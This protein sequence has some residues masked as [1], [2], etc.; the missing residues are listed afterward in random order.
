MSQETTPQTRRWIVVGAAL[1]A[2]LALYF[3]MRH[4]LRNV[5][6]ITT[7]QAAYHDIVSTESTNGQVVPVNDFQASSPAPGTISAIFV[8][9]GQHVAKGQELVQMD[10]SDELNR[11][12]SANST[13][14][15]SQATLKNMQAGGTQDERIAAKADL[16]SAQD[17]L[18]HDREQLTAQQALLAK[19]AAS[20]NEV[21]ATQQKLQADQ[22]HLS[23]LRTRQAGRYGNVDLAAQKAQVSTAE[24][25][26]STARSAL[27]GVHIRAPFAGTVYSAPYSAHDFVPAGEPL[28]NLADLSELRVKAYFDEPEVG[29]LKVGQPVN[30]TWD[31]RPDRTWHGHISLAPT[32]IIV[33]GT[34]HVGE[35]LITVDDAHNDLLPNINVTV[36]VTTSQKAH[37]LCIPR[38]ALH[39]LGES[40]YVFKVVDNHLHK[41]RVSVGAL[42]LTL[43]QI[44]SGL[45]D[46]DI[47]ALDSTSESELTDGLEVK[48]QP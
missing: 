30:I 40:N 25:S 42:N 39:T 6:E 33:Y 4:M 23:E 41:T 7:G 3:M 19:G 47:V 5:V 43:V 38:E 15:A 44:T 22:N 12:S 29:S 28:L 16:A 8:T 37:V 26:V 45:A 48:V 18:A 1:I 17:L 21:A 14:I 20:A 10:D 27:S 24:E 31:A 35:A 9:A 34:R 46:G 2:A 13:L 32:T 36:T 11:L